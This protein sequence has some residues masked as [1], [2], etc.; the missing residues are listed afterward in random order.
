MSDTITVSLDTITPI[1]TELVP[2]CDKLRSLLSDIHNKNFPCS[3]VDESIILDFLS[4]GMAL[5]VIFEEYFEQARDANVTS[6][7]L[8]KKEFAAILS[9]AKTVELSL[10]SSI[11]NTGIWEH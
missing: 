6:L 1:Y 8:T 9:L 5:K 4:A 7:D 10:K 11:V 3:E 2:T